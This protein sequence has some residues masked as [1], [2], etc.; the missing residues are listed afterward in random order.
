MCFLPAS[1]PSAVALLRSASLIAGRRAIN[2]APC[3]GEEKN[4][5]L[6]HFQVESA[7]SH[8]SDKLF[9]VSSL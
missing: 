3:W 5:V 7:F 1:A 9:E 8:F 6:V 4:N 2:I